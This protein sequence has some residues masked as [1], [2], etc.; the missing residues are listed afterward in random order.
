MG[1]SNKAECGRSIFLCRVDLLLESVPVLT[2]MEVIVQQLMVLYKLWLYDP[3]FFDL[4][5]RKLGT[6]IFGIDQHWRVDGKLL[7]KI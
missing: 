7:I 5:W 6:G 3:L 2:F 4:T 1:D